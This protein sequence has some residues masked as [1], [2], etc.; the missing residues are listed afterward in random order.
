MTAVLFSDLRF[1]T[2]SGTAR[3]GDKRAKVEPS[4]AEINRVF[5]NV[6]IFKWLVILKKQEKDRW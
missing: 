3:N 4:L 6:V 2:R 5:C 1:K